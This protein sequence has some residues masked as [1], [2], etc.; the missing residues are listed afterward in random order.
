MSQHL[1]ILPTGGPVFV[2]GTE[3]EYVTSARLLEKQHPLAF[4][5]PLPFTEEA[6]RAARVNGAGAPLAATQARQGKPLN[7]DACLTAV[8]NAAAGEV[9]FAAVADGVS[10]SYLSERG[11]NLAVGV[12]YSLICS[13]LNG[14]NYQSPT[15]SITASDFMGFLSNNNVPIIQAML[16]IAIGDAFSKVC[17]NDFEELKRQLPTVSEKKQVC[18]LT[19]ITMS[20]YATTLLFAFVV[21]ECCLVYHLGDGGILLE[22]NNS[23]NALSGFL[24]KSDPRLHNCIRHGGI[25]G[26]SY[27][28]IF[29]GV[30][31]VVMMT[32][33]AE[34]NL[35]HRDG[36]DTT[37][38]RQFISGFE[39]NPGGVL[40]DLM[41]PGHPKDDATIAM[42]RNGRLVI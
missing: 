25:I 21:D 12:A 38:Y 5:L 10:R 22:R 33:G 35:L 9:K 31:S 13:L 16:D 15:C 42:I 26:N 8:F 34:Q 29:Q 1:F 28:W 41:T 11:S 27:C 20:R 24:P 6:V 37:K 36:R 17:I 40:S 30:N 19:G 2:P 32:D 7:Q 23:V 3:V 18:P 39:Q 14:E 4:P